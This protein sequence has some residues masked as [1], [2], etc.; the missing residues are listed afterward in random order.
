M[1]D[2]IDDYKKALKDH[3]V[4]TKSVTAGVIGSLGEIL[5][6][7]LKFLKDRDG[8]GA[9]EIGVRIRRIVAFFVF[10]AGVNGPFFHWW[11]NKLEEWTSTIQNKRLKVLL[12]L[13]LDRGIL[14]P[15]FLFFTLFTLQVLISGSFQV[16]GLQALTSFRPALRANY[17]LW[18][19]AQIVSF[20]LVPVQFRVLFGNLVALLWNIKL[21]SVS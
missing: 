1:D 21:A 20:S 17:L 18:I 16:S 12:Q 3:P 13:F 5:C 2:L 10:G 14:T 11:Y 7:L 9:M 19:P 8:D 6:Q 4:R 15:P